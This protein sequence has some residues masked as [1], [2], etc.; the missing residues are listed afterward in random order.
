[1][2]VV[3]LYLKDE[4]QSWK[5]IS[6]RKTLI[7]FYIRY[8]VGDNKRHVILGCRKEEYYFIGKP[9]TLNIGTVLHDNTANREGKGSP[10]TY[11]PHL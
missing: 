4:V 3:G 9:M 2:H 5:Q 1:M 10:H 8:L 7:P 11:K 6:Y